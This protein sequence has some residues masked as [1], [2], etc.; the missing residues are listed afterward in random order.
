MKPVRWTKHALQNLRDREI[1]RALAEATIAEPEQQSP[2][3]PLRLIL[4]RRYHDA[5]INQFMLLRVV[6]EET[7]QEVVV[8]TL[9]KT[10]QVRRY[11]K[12]GTR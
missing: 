1:D 9:Y 5:V 3:P 12:E 6:I 11:L 7:D 10:S 2:D 8:I 4:M